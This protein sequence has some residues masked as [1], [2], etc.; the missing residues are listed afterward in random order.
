M[1][2]DLDPSLL[3]QLI[4]T[5]KA[6]LDE[7]AQVMTE[8][9]LKLEKLD[10]K[11]EEFKSN[12]DI[13][14]RA[15]HNIKGAARGIGAADV[16][17]IAHHIETVFSAVQKK[18][19]VLSSGIIDLCL[20]SLDSM[21]LALDA[22]TNKTP[23]PFNLE[24]LL[25][26][27]KK[28][29]EP[30]KKI[31]NKKS[32]QIKNEVKMSDDSSNESIRVS[33]KNLD[34][35]GA[36]MEEVQVNKIAIDDHFAELSQLLKKTNLFSSLWSEARKSIK[37]L[38]DNQNNDT[39]QRLFTLGNDVFHEIVHSTQQIHKYMRSRINEFSILSNSLQDEIRTLRLVPAETLLQTLPR[40][41][42]EIAKNLNKEVIIDISGDQVKM[43]KMILEGLK[44]PLIHLLRNA[45][46]HGIETAEER[47]NLNK[48]K[49][50]HL[51]I[52]VSDEGSQIL[53]TITDDG[54]GIDVG[55]VGEIAKQNNLV[56]EA[57]LAEMTKNEILELI[58]R[59]GFSTKE[60]ITELSGRGVGL[61]VVKT[62]LSNLKGTVSVETELGKNT[63]FFLRVP[64]TLSSERG[65]VVVSS[66]HFFVIPIVHVER[67]LRI[68]MNEIVNVEGTQA[69]L[70]DKRTV[71][72]RTLS[73]AL[74]LQ[75]DTHSLDQSLSIVVLTKSKH[76][77]ALVVDEIIGEREIVIKPLQPP[78]DSL[79]LIRGG[80]LA[81][82]GKVM[83]VLNTNELMNLVLKNEKTKQ[84]NVQEEKSSMQE[85]P[86]IL[87]VDDSITTRTLEKNILETHDYKVTVAVNGKEAWDLLQK[88]PFAL[89]ITDVSMPIMD[90]FTLTENVKQSAKLKDM[91]VIIVTSLGS[92]AEKKRGVEV[93]AD[94][95]I[96][97]NEFES[98][99]LLGIVS[100]LV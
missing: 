26:R 10:P 90:G 94:A 27:L 83:I 78:V 59:P 30:T 88:Q 23:L 95:Y 7:K 92:P 76:S 97:K 46:D 12:I 58:F 37:N 24:E 71:P 44:D 15:A 96:I 85:K 81:G 31:A 55:K 17:E 74:D 6:E 53:I 22:F 65:L 32:K 18:Q 51:G 33:L 13:I 2:M 16:G 50:G 82:N 62:N 61:D 80:T 5:F 45:V 84:L 91:P 77:V 41:V 87:V 20:E 60:I 72:L 69:I 68:S 43:D 79:P 70:F 99:A 98:D 57:D 66:G 3:K 54:A 93:G 56:S 64:L 21:H 86:H 52:K 47:K 11:D 28:A 42:R 73:T 49:E 1:T 39:L 75:E 4:E 38:S 40:I 9:M 19:M 34:S 25:E 36:L 14:F 100:Q 67:V 48:S 35:I 29:D 63:T 89:L 8:S